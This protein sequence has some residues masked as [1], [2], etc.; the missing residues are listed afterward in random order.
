[1][2]IH[3]RHRHGLGWKII[4]L[5]SLRETTFKELVA[6]DDLGW[7]NVWGVARTDILN[8]DQSA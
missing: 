3:S 7:C 8:Q 4:D 5:H 6:T 2:D 1:M